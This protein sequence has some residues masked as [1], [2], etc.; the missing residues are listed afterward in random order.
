M[1]R[2]EHTAAGLPAMQLDGRTA[3]L[4]IL[5]DPV[6]QV[7]APAPL[8]ALLQQRGFNAVLVPL[9][10]R[11]D[12]VALL[13]PALSALHNFAGFIVTVP[14]KQRIASLLSVGLL[15][16]AQRAGATN[17]V[18]RTPQGGWQADLLDGTGFVA[19]LHAAGFDTHGRCAHIV[20][21]GGAASAIAFAL[22]D[23]GARTLRICD[24]DAAKS[25]ALVAQLNAHGVEAGLWDGAD[26]ANADLL[27]NATP[28]G[29][30]AS[31]PLPVPPGALRPGL[32]V[33]DVIM[34]PAVTPLLLAAQAR[35]CRTHEGRHMMERQLALM[36][37]FFAP[38]ILAIAPHLP[39]VSA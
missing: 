9:H 4:G 29:M 6:A 15:S 34:A 35:G 21:A 12:D 38:A 36:A 24:V 2:N 23:A 3:V 31:D 32:W 22:A 1:E 11:A 8:T 17:V 27:V 13:L 28:V 16:A 26:T 30:R 20:G 25:G 19:G 37:D 7:K 39:E 33:A 18:R 14:H 10:V 5:G